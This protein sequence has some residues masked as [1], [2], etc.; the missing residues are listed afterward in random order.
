MKYR[1]DFVT[2][3]SSSSFLVAITKEER[4]EP[5]IHALVTAEGA[6]ETDKGVRCNTIQEVE[7][8]LVKT[9]GYSNQTREEVLQHEY[10]AE[11]YKLAC[12]AINAG[13]VCVFKDIGYSD[14]GLTS[15]LHAMCECTDGIAILKSDD[16]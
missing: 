5:I 16:E 9:W 3:S 6:Y 12:D 7:D 2:N 8:H 11:W 10:V 14:N 4:Y 15:F 1:S 13:K